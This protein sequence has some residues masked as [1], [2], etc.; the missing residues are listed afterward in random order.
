MSDQ[1]QARLQNRVLLRD[2]NDGEMRIVYEHDLRF[3]IGEPDE[4]GWLAKFSGEWVEVCRGDI[5]TLRQM[6]A[7]ATDNDK[8]FDMDHAES[9][10]K[11]NYVR[12]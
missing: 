7:L 2:N 4:E 10:G 12:A 9:Y 11:A 6:A 8:P 5:R 1:P 3:Y